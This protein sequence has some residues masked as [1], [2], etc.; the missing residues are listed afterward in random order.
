[1]YIYVSKMQK[2]VLNMYPSVLSRINRGR[3]KGYET[4]VGTKTTHHVMYPESSTRLGNTTHL[5]FFPFKTHDFLWLMKD[6]N[7]G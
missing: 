4:D 5:L 1:M 7:R 2:C 3:T 6:L